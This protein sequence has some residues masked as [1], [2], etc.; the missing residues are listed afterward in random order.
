MRATL[1]REEDYL[2]EHTLPR[3]LHTTRYFDDRLVITQRGHVGLAPSNIQ[4]GDHIAIL[5]GGCMPFAVRKVGE[6]NVGIQRYETHILLGACYIDGKKML[7]FL[8]SIFTTGADRSTLGIMHGEA[9]HREAREIY[10]ALKS[11][12]SSPASNLIV[13]ARLHHD[14][15]APARPTDEIAFLKLIV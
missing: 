8:L 1:D 12:S 13:D 7:L 4:I 10:E 2:R 11:F 6:E 3:I 14:Q 15:G 9:V 5:A